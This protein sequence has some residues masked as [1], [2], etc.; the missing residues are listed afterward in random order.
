MLSRRLNGVIF[1][2]LMLASW[3]LLFFFHSEKTDDT[4]T[5]RVRYYD[6]ALQ[7]MLS[8]KHFQDPI[9]SLCHHFS[10]QSSGRINFIERIETYQLIS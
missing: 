7:T 2:I 1:G 8:G 6:R 10:G 3:Q 4:Q 9:I 5:A